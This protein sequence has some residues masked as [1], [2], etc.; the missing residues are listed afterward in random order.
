[1]L[2]D[3][4]GSRVPSTP[5]FVGAPPDLENRGK[6]K[7]DTFRIKVSPQRAGLSWTNMPYVLQKRV[8][9]FTACM[10]GKFHAL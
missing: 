7:E 4:L 3:Q 6:K 2:E 10:V 5:H 1:M 8:G 9:I